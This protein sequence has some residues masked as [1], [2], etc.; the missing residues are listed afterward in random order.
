MANEDDDAPDVADDELDALADHDPSSGPRRKRSL[1]LEL[2]LLIAEL[3]ARSTGLTG[4]EL[5]A[6]ITRFMERL[7]EHHLT[8]LPRA[9][10]GE[11]RDVTRMH[12]RRD[13]KLQELLNALR[14]ATELDVARR[15]R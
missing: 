12:L 8:R 4:D 5:E 6:E 7:V 9:L 3:R 13:P 11:M 1:S 10:R 15:S 14:R 2:Q